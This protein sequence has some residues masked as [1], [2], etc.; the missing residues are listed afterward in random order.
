MKRKPKYTNTQ[1]TW[2]WIADQ[3]TN[4]MWEEYK[5]REERWKKEN[6]EW[7]QYEAKKNADK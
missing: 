5:A 2:E 4:G 6:E 3:E 1:L 7:H